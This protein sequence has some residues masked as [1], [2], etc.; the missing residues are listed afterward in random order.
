VHSYVLGALEMVS[1]LVSVEYSYNG[2]SLVSVE[3][4]YSCNGKFI[5]AVKHQSISQA[6]VS[7][8]CNRHA[9]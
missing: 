4:E 6:F 1:A 8:D 5:R 3:Y 2:K 9:W 7:V